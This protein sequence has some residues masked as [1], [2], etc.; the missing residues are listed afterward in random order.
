MLRIHASVSQTWPQ[1]YSNNHQGERKRAALRP[2]INQ[3][4]FSKTWAVREMSTATG[5]NKPINR[6][7]SSCTGAAKKAGVSSPVRKSS[8]QGGFVDYIS[9]ARIKDVSVL[10]VVLDNAVVSLVCYSAVFSVVTHR[11]S[12][13]TAVTTLKTAV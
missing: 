3:T 12:P 10:S 6:K 7:K 11:S 9:Q 1:F 13:Q 8:S 5:I 2:G 4:F